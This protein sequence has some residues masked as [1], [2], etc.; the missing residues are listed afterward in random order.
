[1]LFSSCIYFGTKTNMNTYDFCG[2]LLSLVQEPGHFNG[3]QI[4]LI[5]CSSKSDGCIESNLILIIP[6]IRREEGHLKL[7]LPWLRQWPICLYLELLLSCFS[8]DLLRPVRYL[9][10]YFWHLQFLRVCNHLIV[11]VFQAQCSAAS[12]LSSVTRE[13]RVFVASLHC[14]YRQIKKADNLHYKIFHSSFKDIGKLLG[15]K[16]RFNLYYMTCNSSCKF[17]NL[18][19]SNS[20]QQCEGEQAAWGRERTKVQCVAWRLNSSKFC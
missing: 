10:C 6:N 19:G 18:F 4:I 12:R 15:C 11:L 20:S 13:H 16:H 2:L 3:L 7:C 1:M 9:L 5:Q 14:F 8:S 17:P